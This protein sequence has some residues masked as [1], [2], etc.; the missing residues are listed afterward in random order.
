MKRPVFIK[1][2]NKID[3]CRAMAEKISRWHLNA[4]DRFQYSSKLN[5]DLWWTKWHVDT[6]TP[7][8][9]VSVVSVVPKIH[10]THPLIQD[11]V[12]F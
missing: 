11:I 7:N 9:S 6:F 3:P 1:I 10:H 5:W 2:T 4:K 8:S 12:C